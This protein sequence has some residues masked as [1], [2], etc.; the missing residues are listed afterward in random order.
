MADGES[1]A[2]EVV[3]RLSELARHHE[4]EFLLVIDAIDEHWDVVRFARELDELARRVRSLAVRICI[5]VKTSDWHQFLFERGLRRPLAD[6]VYD[7]PPPEVE[8]EVRHPFSTDRRASG[9]R[10][11]RR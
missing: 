4:T 5:A 11:S 2:V 1:S 7:S 9:G 10:G 3:P 8:A 6:R